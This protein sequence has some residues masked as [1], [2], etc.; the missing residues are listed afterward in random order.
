METVFNG[1]CYVKIDCTQST[2]LQR[3]N[4][5]GYGVMVKKE[6]KEIKA[7]LTGITEIILYILT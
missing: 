2:R 6:W 5:V 7:I 4:E 3:D 1:N